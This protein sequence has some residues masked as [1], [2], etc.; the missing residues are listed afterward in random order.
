M[1]FKMCNVIYLLLLSEVVWHLS[2]DDYL[3][4]KKVYKIQKI[5]WIYFLLFYIV[6][7]T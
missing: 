4:T 1:T 2:V 6:P 7:E 3:R 5:K